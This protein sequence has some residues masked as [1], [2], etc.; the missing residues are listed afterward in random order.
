MSFSGQD[1]TGAPVTTKDLLGKPWI[2]SFIFTRCQGPCPLMTSK[3]MTLAKDLGS[4]EDVG[5]LSFTVDPDY[6][7][8]KVLETYKENN[9]VPEA[10]EWKLIRLKKK[11]LAGFVE[12]AGLPF[13]PGELPVHSSR[14]I[15]VDRDLCLKKYY[16]LENLSAKI[17]MRDIRMLAR[18]SRRHTAG[19]NETL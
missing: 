3:L 10:P 18:L 5:L 8:P 4:R 17:V 2:I 14:F 1:E 13:A 9:I 19:R 16:S 7:F 12:A 15:L 6:D 11:D